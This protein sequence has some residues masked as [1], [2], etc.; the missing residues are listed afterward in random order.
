MLEAIFAIV[1]I[2]VGGGTV[3]GAQKI[4]QNGTQKTVDETLAEAQRQAAD[5]TLNAT[6][7]AKIEADEIRRDAK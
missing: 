6:T 3:F 4:R 2:L 7:T 5:I 1:G